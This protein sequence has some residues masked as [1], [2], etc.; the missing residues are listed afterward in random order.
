VVQRNTRGKVPK[1]TL[2]THV[3]RNRGVKKRRLP[4]KSKHKPKKAKHQSRQSNKSGKSNK[5][6]RSESLVSDSGSEYVYEEDPLHCDPQSDW[7]S[8]DE[9]D[10]VQIVNMEL[11]GDLTLTE[12][13]EFSRQLNEDYFVSIF[14]VCLLRVFCCFVCQKYPDCLNYWFILT[15]CS[16]CFCFLLCQATHWSQKSHCLVVCATIYQRFTPFFLVE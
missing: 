4:A 2:H 5:R 11:A 10:R 1:V 9:D 13:G 14:F 15:V 3:S 16:S 8:V 12:E 6:V 7:E